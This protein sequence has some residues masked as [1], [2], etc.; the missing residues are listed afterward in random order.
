MFRSGLVGPVLRTSD[1]TPDVYKNGLVG[2]T[3]SKR[4][5]TRVPISKLFDLDDTPDHETED[6]S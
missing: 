6:E 5:I 4:A 1:T 3:V 2:L